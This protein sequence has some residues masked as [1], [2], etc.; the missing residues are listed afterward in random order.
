MLISRVH[1][2]CNRAFLHG[3][4]IATRG[5][6]REEK[7]ENKNPFYIFI[8]MGILK[9]FLIVVCL[10]QFLRVITPLYRVW[11]PN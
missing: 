1:F 5:I 4:S 3:R 2:L 11:Y 7:K 9:L 8:T 6:N 10:F